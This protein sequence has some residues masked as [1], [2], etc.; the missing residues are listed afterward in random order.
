MSTQVRTKDEI[1]PFWMLELP[2]PHSR[3]VLMLQCV[4]VAELN[5]MTKMNFDG[6]H[7]Y[8]TEADCNSVA[9]YMRQ[10]R[11]DLLI[12]VYKSAQHFV[13]LSINNME[14]EMGK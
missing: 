13:T 6:T 1:A 8:K 5:I 2:R 14:M 4:A 10:Q 9:A 7:F 11:P 3:E 12:S